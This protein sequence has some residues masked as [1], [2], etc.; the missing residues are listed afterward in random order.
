[1]NRFLKWV[2]VLIAVVVV[3]VVAAAVVLPLLFDSDDLKS[4]ISTAVNEE[5]GRELRIDGDLN[6]SVF[7]VLA[8]EVDRLTLGN[9]PGFGDAPFAEIGQARVGVAVLPLLK[10][11]VRADEILLS[12]LRM[13]LV[14]KP[15]GTSNWAD[16]AEDDSSSSPPQADQV[17]SRPTPQIAGLNISDAQIEYRDEQTGLHYR[18]AGFDLKT[19][20]LSADSPVP[21]E[22]TMVL[23]D[24][25]A[26]TGVEL[27]LEA[28]ARYEPETN[29]LSLPNVAMRLDE[30]RIEG[31]LS[32]GVRDAAPP[33]L[34]FDL[35][36]DAIDL[37]R[38]LAPAETG[39][40]VPDEAEPV[41]IP[42]DELAGLD[43]EGT[44]RI[45]RLKAMEMELSDVEMRLGVRDRVMRLNPLTASFYGG[46]YDGDITLDAT[47]SVSR[48]TLNE[49]I[50]AVAFK[51]LGSDLLGSDQVS[52][53]AFGSLQATGSGRNSDEL[54]ND[55]AG[56][57]NL[58]LDEGA[59]EGIDIWY[60][61]RRAIA[62]AKGQTLPDGGQGR[63]VFSRMNVDGTLGQGVLQLD[64]LAAELPFLKV[65]G[66]G[67]V[68]LASTVL[69]IDLVAGV[70]DVP[71]LAQDPL[72]ADLEGRSIP[73]TI[74]GSA[75]APKVS[76][77]V[78][79]LLKGEVSRRLMDK[80]GLGQE[81]SGE[82]S[83]EDSTDQ[84]VKGLLGGLLGKKKGE[85]KD[86]G[87]N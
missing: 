18:L 5:T 4:K 6:F 85:E 82:G 22:L 84:A 40:T 39:Q 19:G 37:D 13:N 34:R 1:M 81:G 69:D 71:E 41:P 23:E 79:S 68:N 10:R 87:G 12:G 62:L 32:L 63:T 65:A 47:R 73:L 66:A 58:R 57:L 11:E 46:N 49:R 60:E 7:P 86:D 8:L 80:L 64:E 30:S 50:E 74:S 59:L 45:T 38:Y 17:V 48:L 54:L 21:I 44:L 83:E 42:N 35:S 14:V 2:L 51:Q 26:G 61:I 16:L 24:I 20:I 53:A 43:V 9:A 77:D 70:R 31:A 75:V 72:A 67:S 25:A 33:S 78:E 3:L 29:T 52:G 36:V 56:K 28:D 15:D 27:D 55:L 76:V